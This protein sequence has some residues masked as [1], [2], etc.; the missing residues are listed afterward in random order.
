M[1]QEV[2]VLALEMGFLEN[3]LQEKKKKRKGYEQFV[4]DARTPASLARDSDQTPNIPKI[5]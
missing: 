4:H 2:R 3:H 1:L 5:L